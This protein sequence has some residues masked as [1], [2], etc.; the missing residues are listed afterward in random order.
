MRASPWSLALDLV[1]AFRHPC[2]DRLVL[3]LLNRKMFSADDFY[4]GKGK[5]MFLK[6]DAIRRFL[7]VYEEWMIQKPA[8]GVPFREATRRQAEAFVRHLQK[9]A[10]WEPYIWMEE[11]E[12]CS[13]SS[14]TI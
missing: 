1:E 13:T 3:T 12:P 11:D 9:K 8:V 6:Q 4:E 7:E 2:A 10:E 14:V 5:G